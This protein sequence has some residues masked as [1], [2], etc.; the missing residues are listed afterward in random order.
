[1][2]TVHSVSNRNV[3]FASA[4][5]SAFFFFVIRFPHLSLSLSLALCTSQVVPV[6]PAGAAGRR[7]YDRNIY[8]RRRDVGGGR[9]ARCAARRIWR[10]QGEVIQRRMGGWMYVCPVSKHNA[11]T[12]TTS[13]HAITRHP[14]AAVSHNVHGLYDIL[15]GITSPW[16]RT[17]WVVPLSCKRIRETSSF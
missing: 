5:E 7:L 9:S 6:R 14:H 8:R 17:P 16:G 2:Y 4:S 12:H 3:L 10:K 11:R 1:M 15:G 13:S